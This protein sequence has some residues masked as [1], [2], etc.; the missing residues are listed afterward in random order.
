MFAKIL[1]PTFLALSLLTFS[2]A[3]AVAQTPAPQTVSFSREELAQMVA[4]IALYPDTLLGNVLMASTY[5]FEVA[6]AAQYVK[7]NPN[8]SGEQLNGAL[9]SRDWDESVKALCHTP[10]VV[11]MMSD[12]LDWMQK[13]GDAFLADPAAVTMAVQD[14]RQR[15]VDAGQLMDTPQQQVITENQTIVIEPTEPDTLYVPYYDPTYAYGYW[16]YAAYPPYY[17]PYAGYGLAAAGIGFLAGA[18]IGSWWNNA[19][20]DWH[21]GNIN[22]DNNFNRF[23]D[24]T[25]IGSGNRWQHRPEHRRG[26]NYRDAATRERFGRGDSRGAQARQDFR[27]RAQGELGQGGF[28]GDRGQLGQG[29]LGDRGQLG[30]GGFGGDRGQLGQG[31]FGGDRG[32]LGQGGFG[33]GRDFGQGG[34]F[35]GNR[36]TSV[37]DRRGN[38]SSFNGVG[39]GGDARLD[40]GRGSF[41]RGG[42]GFQSARAS[43]SRSGGFSRSSGGMRAGGGGGFRGGGGGGMRGGGGRR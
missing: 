22:I 35:G 10:Q 1:R 28:G 21:G 13:L 26:A 7:A 3:S 38:M 17:Y 31:G 18:A 37:A 15:S 9:A 8:V 29:G 20:V 36:G 42:G 6:Q 32:Q 14:L 24:R 39:R 30:Q 43:G 34:G 19:H 2:A 41:S 16:P 40:S 5:P 33:G 11:T 4:P 12:R 27:G 25:N 23:G